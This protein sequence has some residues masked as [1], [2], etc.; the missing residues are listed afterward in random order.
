M[1]LATTPA[2]YT[3]LDSAMKTRKPDARTSRSFYI[4][5]ASGPRK[6]TVRWTT[7]ARTLTRHLRSGS[8]GRMGSSVV[9]TR[10]YTARADA[11]RGLQPVPGS[12]AVAG[13]DG[14]LV[15][16]NVERLLHHLRGTHRRLRQGTRRPGTRQLRLRE[17]AG[18]VLEAVR[19]GRSR[20]R[21]PAHADR[22]QVRL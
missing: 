16:A 17:T 12:Q 21:D 4:R 15:A 19:G 2:Y 5:R 9:A 3:R 22:V 18:E 8:G 10:N 11:P 1:S 14:L 7:S 6:F 20:H 13:G